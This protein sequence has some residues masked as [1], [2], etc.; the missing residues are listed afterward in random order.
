MSFPTLRHNLLVLNDLMTVDDRREMLR[1]VGMGGAEMVRYLAGNRS[2]TDGRLT[3]VSGFF[4]IEANL[5]YK[6]IEAHVLLAA[7]TQLA[8][9]RRE[10]TRR[11][12]A[13]RN[14]RCAAS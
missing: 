1:E 5:R 3:Q 12:D 4:G 13:H 11:S 9:R 2:P 7:H 14:A 6:A 8:R 10:R